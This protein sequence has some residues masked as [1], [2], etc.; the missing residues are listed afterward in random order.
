MDLMILGGYGYFVWPSFI[1][2]FTCCF[3]LYLRTK[4]ELKIYEQKFIKEFKQLPET[5]IIKTPGVKENHK[6]PLSVHTF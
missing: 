2:T 1:F 3:L 5:N 6:E 4:N